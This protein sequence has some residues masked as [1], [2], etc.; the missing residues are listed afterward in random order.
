MNKILV[1]VV[2]IILIFAGMLILANIQ[3]TTREGINYQWQEIKIPLYLKVLN[4]FD[5]HFN[6][7]QLVKRIIKDTQGEEERALEIFKW[8]HSNIRSVP[9]GLPVI[10]DHVWN[11]IVRGYGAADQSPYVFVTLCNYA[12][13]KAFCSKVQTKDG[14]GEIMLS[15][16]KVGQNWAAFDPHRGI[17]FTNKTGNLANMEDLKTDNWI[18]KNI[19]NCDLGFDYRQYLEHLPEV[20]DIGLNRANI[21]SPL[22]RLVYEI[23]KILNLL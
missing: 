7:K 17:Y 11:I 15:F 20:K 9:E 12:R 22:G 1:R 10:D 2:S 19:S 14:K 3:L 5:R 18:I 4:F 21:Q 16:A 13:I 8:T 6:Y 23:K